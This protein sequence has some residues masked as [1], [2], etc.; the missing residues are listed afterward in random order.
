MTPYPEPPLTPIIPTPEHASRPSR[1]KRVLFSV[2]ATA[3][4]LYGSVLVLL[5]FTV[6]NCAAFGGRCGDVPPPIL[7]DDV[8]GMAVAGVVLITTGPVISHW[9]RTGH[10]WLAPV[11]AG[12][13]I[14]VG[15]MA[16]ASGY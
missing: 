2:A 11:A 8:A 3:A 1:V 4:A 6:G 9:R 16:R 14:L 13:A 7:D 5:A 12:A 15:L 10:I